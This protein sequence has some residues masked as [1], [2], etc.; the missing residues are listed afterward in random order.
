[1]LNVF[2]EIKVRK[3]LHEKTE[4]IKSDITYFLKSS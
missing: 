1:M 2:K 4:N 3:Y